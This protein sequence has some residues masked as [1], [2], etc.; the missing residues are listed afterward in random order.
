VPLK[1]SLLEAKTTVNPKYS[2]ACIEQ[3][4]VKLAPVGISLLSDAIAAAARQDRACR[5]ISFS[6]RTLK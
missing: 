4:L 1:T 6:E 3:A 5:T 2:E